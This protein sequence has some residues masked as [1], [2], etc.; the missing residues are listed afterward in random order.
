[1]IARVL[2]DLL[3]YASLIWTISFYMYLLVNY[4]LGRYVSSTVW[5]LD[6]DRSISYIAQPVLLGEAR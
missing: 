3:N 6:I 5:K 1:M 2:I 4:I